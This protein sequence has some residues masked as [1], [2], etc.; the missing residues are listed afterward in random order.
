MAARLPLRI[1]LAE[2]NVVNQKVALLTLGRLGYR[3]DVAG[4]GLEALQAIARQHYDVVLMDVQ[5][6]ELD[7]IEA[8]RRLRRG[9]PAGTSPRVIAMT[10]NA[11][12]GDREQ[13]LGAGMDDYLSKPVRVE[14]L[15]QALERAAAAA[16]PDGGEAASLD[17]ARQLGDAP[18]RDD[19]ATAAPPAA[20]APAADAPRPDLIDRGVLDDLR[21]DFGDDNPSLVPDLIDLFL[22]DAPQLLAR[23]KA[24][25]AE[26]AADLAYRAAHTLKSTSANLGAR[27]LVTRCEALE[28]LARRGR[29]ADG[30]EQVR[31]IEVVYPEVARALQALRAE[32]AA[33]R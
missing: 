33:A 9:R 30:V 2:D 11:M 7:G 28:A 4:N 20:P 17:D 29:L 10:A 32:V 3:A 8:T 13:C 19:L 12:Q 23:L 27:A 24:A 16:R 5:M 15:V 18:W 31:Q 21:A 25:V 1:L 26:D 6:P 22:A 14:E